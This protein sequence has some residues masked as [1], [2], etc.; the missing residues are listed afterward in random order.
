MIRECSWCKKI[1]GCCVYD[2]KINCGDELCTGICPTRIF[3][4]CEITHGICKECK[5]REYRL[6][7][8]LTPNG[9]K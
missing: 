6:L 2:E 1:I 3:P 5:E 8:E 4:P 9:E 7:E